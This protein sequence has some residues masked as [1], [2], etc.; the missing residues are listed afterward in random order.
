[1][2]R[3]GE[4]LGDII[5]DSRTRSAAGLG[6]HCRRRA[7]QLPSGDD[8]GHRPL[9]PIATCL[10]GKARR[11]GWSRRS[12]CLSLRLGIRDFGG[13]TAADAAISGCRSV[14]TLFSGSRC[15]RSL[16]A[17]T[18]SATAAALS[19]D[20]RRHGR[21]CASMARRQR[22]CD[23]SS[24]GALRSRSRCTVRPMA[25]RRSF[26]LSFRLIGPRRYA[27]VAR[28]TPDAPRC[29]RS[30]IAARMLPVTATMVCPAT[31]PAMPSVRRY[32]LALDGRL[33]AIRR[34]AFQSV[35]RSRSHAHRLMRS[36][37]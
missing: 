1:M 34:R 6:R 27:H 18:P 37:R 10:G 12:A 23:F 4:I 9:A 13:S 17:M 31:R 29:T 30:D 25:R 28:S 21:L 8:S 2:A 33:P 7:G 32:Y 3:Q 35:K 15:Q 11:I 19:R 16:A 20:S 22:S 14:E 26:R 36:P 24:L 5:Q